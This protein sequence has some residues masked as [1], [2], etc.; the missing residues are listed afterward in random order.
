MRVLSRILA[1]T[2]SAG[3]LLAA[4]AAQ[5]AT[6]VPLN[7]SPFS[8]PVNP[9]GVIPAAT[10]VQGTGT[11]DFT[12]TTIGGTYKTLMQMQ[13]SLVSNGVPQPLTFTLFSGVP[14]SGTMVPGGGSGGSPT[15]ATLLLPLKAGSYYME[16]ATTSVG[17]ELATG[18]LTL[19]SVVP[20]PAAWTMLLAGFGGLGAMMRSRRRQASGASIA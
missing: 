15:A 10:F 1:T 14:G 5:A 8:L 17:K 13:T 19:L 16:L 6:I 12:F 20:E 4:A 18:G 3:V 2:V 9:S 7:T 11:W